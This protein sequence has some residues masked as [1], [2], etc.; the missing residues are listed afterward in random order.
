MTWHRKRL[1][2]R[3][4][5]TMNNRTTVI[6]KRARRALALLLSLLMALSLGVLGACGNGDKDAHDG[7]GDKTAGEKAVLYKTTVVIDVS[8]AVEEGNATAAEFESA[9]GADKRFELEVPEGSTMLEALRATGL[10]VVTEKASFGEYVTAINLL[11]SGALGPESG[12]TFLVNDEFA[13]EGADAMKV[14]DGDV[15]T[16]RYVTKYE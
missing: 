10:S 3:E 6:R 15:V 13:L 16:W 11:E 9:L 2:T 14:N 7:A 1:R 12:W 5:K 8:A 4:G